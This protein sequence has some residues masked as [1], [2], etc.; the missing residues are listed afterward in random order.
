MKLDRQKAGTRHR[1]LTLHHGRLGERSETTAEG[2][3]AT[4]RVSDLAA[5]K[6]T[7]RL[8]DRGAD[9]RGRQ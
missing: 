5:G 8:S 4:A 9:A 3:P 6:L 7:P 2:W 1:L